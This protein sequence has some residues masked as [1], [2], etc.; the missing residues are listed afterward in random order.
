MVLFLASDEA[1]FVNG[2][3]HLRRQRLHRRLSQRRAKSNQ[4]GSDFA[5]N[6]SAFRNVGRIKLK[7]TFPDIALVLRELDAHLAVALG[8]VGPVLAH[9][10]EEEEV[11]RL[12]GDL[13]DFRARRHRDR[14]DRLRRPC[15]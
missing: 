9:L 13:R 6:S 12:L 11:D 5:P 3:Q 14:L 1:S 2:A 8:I 10:D 4:I 15:R 7:S